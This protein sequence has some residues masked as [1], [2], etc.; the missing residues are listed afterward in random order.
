[1]TSGCVV[2][3]GLTGT[4]GTVSNIRKA[5]LAAGYRVNAPCLAGHGGTVEDLAKVTWQD[6]YKTARIAYQALRKDC[7][8]VFCVGT[9]LGA[10]LSLKLAI[11]EG[12]GLKAIGC[13]A[14]PLRL[15]F[16]ENIAVKFVKYTV[17]RDV[18]KTIPKDWEKS[19]ADEEGREE[20]ERHSLPEIPTNAVYE[21]TRLQSVV[22]SGLSKLKSPVLIMHGRHDHVAPIFNVNLLRRRIRSRKVEVR[23]FENSRHVISMD[24]DRDDVAKTTVEFFNKFA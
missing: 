4:P 10:L 13:M 2:I 8:R 16:L 17:L 1:M 6:W 5:L 18:I 23:I 21:I 9:S 24:Y 22:L 14:T 12:H 20:Y 11:D 3:H 15:S 7:D 19:V